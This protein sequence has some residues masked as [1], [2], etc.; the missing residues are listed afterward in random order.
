MRVPGITAFCT[1]LGTSVLLTALAGTPALASVVKLA[2]TTYTTTL[3]AASC[4]T[5]T[6]TVPDSPNASVTIPSSI[7]GDGSSNA[8][9]LGNAGRD[10]SL[11]ASANAVGIGVNVSASISLQYYVEIFGPS[12]I[13]SVPV[14]VTVNTALS[15]GG[16]TLAGA[17]WTSAAMVS[18][19][20]HSISDAASSINNVPSI[21]PSTLIFDQAITLMTDKPYSI[22]LSADVQAQSLVVGDAANDVFASVDPTLTVP[23]GFSIFFSDGIGSAVPEPSTWIMLLIGF[24]GLGFMAY[25]RKNPMALNAA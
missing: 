12:G 5:A 19:N 17:T 7:P 16:E 11:L 22:N 6:V 15:V 21:A 20:S 3:C 1:P 8:L 14:P 13:V 18:L 10:P 24:C 4:T 9:V 23:D 2:P 25:R